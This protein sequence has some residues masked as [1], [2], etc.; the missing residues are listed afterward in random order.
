M[1]SILLIGPVFPFLRR[2]APGSPTEPE[3]PESTCVWS[4][5]E[6]RNIRLWLRL[7]ESLKW[8][9]TATGKPANPIFRKPSANWRDSGASEARQER[10]TLAPVGGSHP[11]AHHG[12][13]G[14]VLGRSTRF[15]CSQQLLRAIERGQSR[16]PPLA[17]GRLPRRALGAPASR[18]SHGRRAHSTGTGQPEGFSNSERK[19]SPGAVSESRRQSTRHWP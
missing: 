3:L 2:A 17:A 6:S 10:S 14:S 1:L 9:G 13:A 5:H 8:F 15:R 19:D 12:G 7:R 18:S 16:F 4:A 11:A